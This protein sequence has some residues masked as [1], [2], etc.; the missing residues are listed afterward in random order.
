MSDRW[1]SLYRPDGWARDEK[2][3]AERE[4]FRPV[5]AVPL[6]GDD[7]HRI[8]NPHGYETGYGSD[9][10]CSPIVYRNAESGQDNVFVHGT[11]PAMP[12]PDFGGVE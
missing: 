8:S 11:M 10:P 5:H 9:C 7:T 12:I 1:L 4:V 6:D 3:R 2:M